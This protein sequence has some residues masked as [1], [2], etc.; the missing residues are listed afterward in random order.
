MR[1]TLLLIFVALVS[2]AALTLATS[3][4]RNIAWAMYT[5]LRGRFTVADR[6][7]QYGDAARA[8]LI[9]H[10]ERTGVRYPPGTV[11][12][13]VFKDQRAM[14]VYAGADESSLQFVTEYPI[15]GLSGGPGPKL[16]AGDGQVPEG[17]YR[18]ESLNPNSR[19]HLSLRLNYP[20]DSDRRMAQ[21][22]GRT[23]LGSDIMIHGGAASIGCLAM[24][25][26]AVEDLF[27]LAADAGQSNVFVV[28]SP[29]DFRKTKDWSTPPALPAWVRDLHSQLRVELQAFPVHDSAQ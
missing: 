17:R 27:I 13:L 23:S 1:R 21:Q 9:P 11:V 28:I 8:R 24:G 6:L 5:R 18:I 4:G 3:S 26:P 12:L 29:V 16:R 10:F 7:Q 19:Y 2:L 14:Q 25:D 22:D 15:K 20:N